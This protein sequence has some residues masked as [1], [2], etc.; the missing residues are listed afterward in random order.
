MSV[1]ACIC[2]CECMHPCAFMRAY[3]HICV[4]ALR[5]AFVRVSTRKKKGGGEWLHSYTHPIIDI[6]F[7]VVGYDWQSTPEF[8]TY[9]ANILLPQTTRLARQSQVYGRKRAVCGDNSTFTATKPGTVCATKKNQC[10]GDKTASHFCGDKI[11]LN[12]RLQKC[13][14]RLRRQKYSPSLRR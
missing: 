1:R 9:G 10:C 14:P 13:P 6:Y 2:V 12:S 3:V 7:K 11:A 4:L 5:H 8:E